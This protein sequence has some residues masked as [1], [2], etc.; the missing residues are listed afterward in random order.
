MT[1]EKYLDVTSTRPV[2]W[3]NSIHVK[4][5]LSPKATFYGTL[6]GKFLVTPIIIFSFHSPIVSIV[7]HEFT[8]HFG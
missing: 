8:I 3:T 6:K 1:V 7:M 2:N 5:E 4:R